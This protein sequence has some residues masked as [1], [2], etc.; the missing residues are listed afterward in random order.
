MWLEVPL[1]RSQIGADFPEG[2]VCLNGGS[3]PVLK[4]LE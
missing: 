3:L 2:T 4:D 1:G